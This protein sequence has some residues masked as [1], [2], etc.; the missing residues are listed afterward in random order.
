MRR[1]HEIKIISS[2]KTRYNPQREGQQAVRAVDKRAGELTPEYFQKARNTDRLFCGTEPGTT[3]PVETRLGTMGHV[4]GI[5]LG[6]TGEGSE[7]LHSLIHHLALSRVRVAGPQVGRR[8]Q[9]RQE[10]AEGAITTAFLR[11]SI[12]VCAVRGQAWTLLSRLEVLG[13]G[14]AAAARRRGFALDLERR[15]A[16]QRR[17][18]ALSAAQGRAVVRRGHFLT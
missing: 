18:Q 10:A 9:V 8:G 14:A 5:V 2:S 6:A 4:E 7:P 16:N 11:R 3:G 13:P 17:A 15:Y 12:S 1:L